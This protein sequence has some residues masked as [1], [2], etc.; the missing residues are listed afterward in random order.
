MRW[1]LPLFLIGTLLAD[2]KQ[3]F[4]RGVLEASRGN[5]PR[6]WFEKA[7]EKDPDAWPLV[8]RVAG[9]R[10][11]VGEIEG[12]STLYREFAAKH[13]ERIGAQVAYADFLRE[14]SP[15]DDFAAKL[16]MEVLEKAREREPESMG[17]TRRL[18]RLYEQRGMRENSQALFEELEQQDGASVAMAAAEIAR[19][20]FAGDDEAMRVRVDG[21]YQRAMAREPGNPVLAREASEYFRNS[22]RLDEAVRMLEQHVA[23]DPTSLKLRVRLGIL[24]FAADRDDDAVRVLDEVL[25]IDPRQG[26]AHQS[27][28][29][30]F[31]QTG[32]EE[33]ARGHAAE[34]LKIR[35]GDA[36]EFAEL[37][38]ELLAAGE[39]RQA[40]LLLEKGM[41]DHPEDGEIAVLLAVATRQD[42][43][44]K[45]RAASCFREAEALAG[46]EEAGADPAFLLSFA[47]YLAE[48]GES[49]AAEKRLRAAI[50]AYPPEATG[51]TAS[52]LRKLAGLWKAE[53]RNA[54]A[55]K[56]L[57]RRADALDPA[58]SK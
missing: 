22:G 52:A 56:A 34:A 9:I 35:G 24:L 7:L 38:R 26:L 25:A 54:A 17:V 45:D 44:T 15:D 1:C 18:F 41:F 43:E 4:A 33:R 20:L 8:S 2:P 19:N 21:I 6:A 5:D 48:V 30:H 37:G 12:A 40:R 53:D 58:G 42:P 11:R 16:A 49:A 14:V 28:A 57:R 51:E 47:D 39:A 50:K 55:A 10:T 3:D 13:P 29:K 32:D 36:D 23:A 27:L 46:E 31:R